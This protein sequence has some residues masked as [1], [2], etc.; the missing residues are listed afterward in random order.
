MRG[1]FQRRVDQQAAAPLGI[2]QRALKDLFDEL[3]DCVLRG[4][5]RLEPL[6]ARAR[7]LIEVA[8]QSGGEDRALAAEGVVE[9]GTGNSHRG[10]ELAHGGRFVA[11]SP[12]AAHRRI[13]R[14]CLVE[15]SRSRHA[16]WAPNSRTLTFYNDRYRMSR[17]GTPALARTASRIERDPQITQPRRPCFP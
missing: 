14:G 10:R 8:L 17:T 12:E 4:P 3:T 13:Q 15:F 11:A 7:G 5:R 9:A 1:D 6:D 16:L 2:D